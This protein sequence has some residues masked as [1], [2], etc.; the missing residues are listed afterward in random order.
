MKNPFSKF[1]KFGSICDFATRKVIA[2]AIFSKLLNGWEDEAD[3]T[4]FFSKNNEMENFGIAVDL[5]LAN[6]L[7]MEMTKNN[8]L[9]AE[10]ITKAILDFIHKTKRNIAA[11]G[12]PYENEVKMADSFA[13]TSK[14]DF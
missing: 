1:E 6:P 2:S 8:P 4:D 3:N 14:T 13:S 9:L 7:L 11:F 10:E 5:I 12:N